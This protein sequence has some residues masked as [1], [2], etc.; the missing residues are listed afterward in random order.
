MVVTI[1]EI[2]EYNRLRQLSN[3]QAKY[4]SLLEKR[5]RKVREDKNKE[6]NKKA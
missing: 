6:F 5:L 3:T 4:I 2:R 1:I